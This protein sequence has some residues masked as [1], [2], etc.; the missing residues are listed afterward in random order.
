MVREEA[1]GGDSSDA[2]DLSD[3]SDLV[4]AAATGRPGK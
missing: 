4:M 2:S 1:A 3:S